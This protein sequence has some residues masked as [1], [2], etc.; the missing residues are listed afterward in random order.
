MVRVKVT[1]YKTC[2]LYILVSLSFF[3]TIPKTPYWKW[4]A[5]ISHSSTRKETDFHIDFFFKSPTSLRLWPNAF[6]E[7]RYVKF[8]CAVKRTLGAWKRKP[9][10][11]PHFQNDT[12]VKWYSRSHA[13]QSLNLLLCLW[14]EEL[15]DFCGPFTLYICTL[16]YQAHFKNMYIITRKH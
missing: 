8:P 3:C 5:I 12:A 10:F 13:P 15:R 16:M 1:K 9:E 2:N 7:K 11:T 14:R 4:G 6:C